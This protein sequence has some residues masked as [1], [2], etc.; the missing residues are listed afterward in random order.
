MS[1]SILIAMS[2]LIVFIL[3]AVHLAYTYLSPK[4]DPREADLKTRLQSAHLVITRQSTFWRV[5][6]GFNAS[7]S[8]GALLFGAVYGYLALVHKVF[9]AQSYFL[10]GLG[11]V[12]L[13]AY[14]ALAKTYWFS[15]PFRLESPYGK[16]PLP[17]R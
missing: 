5:W 15:I 6:I 12:V 7:H 14:V 2:A 1:G 3:G 4:F 17:S 16:V 11:L 8:L 13:L 9:L 10:L